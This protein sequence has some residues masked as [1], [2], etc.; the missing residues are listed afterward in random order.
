MDFL[1]ERDL[2]SEGSPPTGCLPGT[3]KQ[4]IVS[5]PTMSAVDA[6]EKTPTE[7]LNQGEL[8]DPRVD[9]QEFAC[10]SWSLMVTRWMMVFGGILAFI[11]SVYIFRWIF[12][13]F[14]ER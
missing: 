3:L 10:L 12:E 4:N 13:G 9:V 11:L 8:I 5:R 2:L 7:M 14:R 1:S 6:Y